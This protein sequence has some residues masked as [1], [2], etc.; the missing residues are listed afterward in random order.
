MSISDIVFGM[1]SIMLIEAY[2]MG[3]QCISLQPNNIGSDLLVLSR[4]NY[5]KR[6]DNYSSFEIREE[7]KKIDSEN[8]HYKFKWRESNCLLIKYLG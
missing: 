6:I 5:I 4:Y 7:N 1:T 8:C 3:K 2:I